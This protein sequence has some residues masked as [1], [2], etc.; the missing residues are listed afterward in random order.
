MLEDRPLDQ[1]ADGLLD[2]VREMVAVVEEEDSPS[3]PSEDEAQKGQIGLRRVAGPTGQ[4]QVVGPVV[5]R[6]ALPRLDMIEE[7]FER[8]LFL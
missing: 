8:P 2:P 5:G 6:L 7:D 3:P 1:I 4:H